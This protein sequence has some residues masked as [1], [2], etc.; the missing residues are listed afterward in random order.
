MSNMFLNIVS[1]FKGDGL[2]AATRQLGA[3]G[4]SAGGLG[5]V[6]GRVGGALASFGLAAKAVQFTSQSIDSARDLERNL[7]SIKT[8]FDDLAPQMIEFTKNAERI[9]LSQKDAAKASTFLGSVLKQSG[10]EMGFVQV[11]TEKLVTLAQ[12]LATTYGYDVQEA[13]LGMTA[14]F[15]GEYDP[16][17]KFG[18]AMKQSEINSELAARGLDKLEG[19]ARRNAEQTIRLELLYQRAS[20]ASGAFTAQ[21]GNLYVEQKKLS[22]AW[23]NMQATVGTQLLPA[24]GAL[25]DALKPLVDELTPRLVQIV[26]DAQPGLEVFT[27]LIRDIGDDSTTTGATVGFFADVLGQAFKLISENFGVLLQLTALIIGVN[28]AVRLLSTA[29]IFLNAHPVIAGLTL[30]A[31]AFIL[32]NEG[33]KNLKYNVDTTGRSVTSF[34]TTLKDS[35]KEG[36]YV[37]QKYGVVGTTFGIVTAEA[38]RLADGVKA[39]DR[40]KL[41]NLKNQI[42][43]VKFS[44]SAAA[45]ELER[46]ATFAGIKL[47]E[48]PPS[49]EIPTTP[50]TSSGGGKST[51]KGLTLSEQL[52]KEGKIAAKES[53]LIGKGISEGLADKI[54][55]SKTPIKEANKV[56]KKIADTGGKYATKLQNQ[57]NKTKAGQAELAQQAAE[58]QAIADEAA[59]Q[60]SQAAEEAAR[61]AEDFAREQARYQEELAEQAE[62]A[63]RE[64]RELAEEQAKELQRIRDEEAKA[65]AE[66]LAERERIYNSFLDSVK[67]TFGSIRDSIL[68]AFDIT[69]LGGSTNS[70]IRNM[71]KLLET[72]KAFSANITKLSQMGLNPALLAQVI[73]AGPLA[74]AKLAA[75]LVAG[76]ATALGQINAGY[77]EFGNLASGIAQVGTESRFSTPQQ[78]NIY[79]IEVNGG[80]GSG[81]T[82]GRSIVEAIKAYERTSGAVWVG[83]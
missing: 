49:I 73:Q 59:R 26:N 13:L 35:V 45:R 51:T 37:N 9:G 72:T 41:G 17:E 24:M 28:T 14:L 23:E 33:V 3:F 81:A 38:K 82:I 60:A 4:K 63:A 69:Q 43:D 31:G 68:N 48:A 50:T 53:K 40:A 12:D 66:A 7:F 71:K 52:A 83:A 18:V 54:L 47:P 30:L 64:A 74:G 46:M 65:E 80:V 57:Y 36:Q 58:Q 78:Q 27:Q 62:R 32:V 6:L 19:A 10:F 39:A 11:E 22:A 67:N 76:G 1:T 56:L 20:D 77:G 25:V 61:M 2:S 29:L 16:I 42:N 5:S 70:I 44:A 21:S 55:S 15:R 75:S 8:V 34:N 79:N